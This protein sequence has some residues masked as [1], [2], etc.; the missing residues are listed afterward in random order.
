[1]EVKLPSG[2]TA[3]LDSLPSLLLSNS[4]KK[5]ETKN[6]DT[7]VIMYFEHVR[8]CYERAFKINHNEDDYYISVNLYF[9][10]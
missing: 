8:H 9:I 3:D 4:V 7:E 1:M 2:F 10:F 5:V 6:G